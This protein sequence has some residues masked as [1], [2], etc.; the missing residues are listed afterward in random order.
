M[1]VAIRRG[2]QRRENLARTGIEVGQG[3][4]I[5]HKDS[6]L[7]P[8]KPKGDIRQHGRG[9][10]LAGGADQPVTGRMTERVVDGLEI[11]EI[12]D[13][14]RPRSRLVAGH[15]GKGHVEGRSE[16]HTSELQSLM[17][18]SYDVFCLQKKNTKHRKHIRKHYD[19]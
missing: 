3:L 15:A 18:I 14:Q 11:I 9:D 10:P 17:S 16:E 19:E 1:A 7:V 6:E 5:L 8:A 2:L 12:D 13:E 4:R